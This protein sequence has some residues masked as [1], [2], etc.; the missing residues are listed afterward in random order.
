MQ[1]HMIFFN[2]FFYV[3]DRFPKQNKNHFRMLNI[4]YNTN[5]LSFG[6]I[7]LSYILVW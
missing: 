5:N 1:M 7:F 4:R 6:Y 3:K 2:L